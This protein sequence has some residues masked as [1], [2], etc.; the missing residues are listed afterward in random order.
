MARETVLINW[1]Q[2]DGA[3]GGAKVAWITGSLA[4]W[5]VKAVPVY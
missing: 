2:D 4:N 1:L 3:V 5:M